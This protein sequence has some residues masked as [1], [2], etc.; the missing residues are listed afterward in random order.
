[1]NFADASFYALGEIELK[2]AYFLLGQKCCRFKTPPTRSAIWFMLNLTSSDQTPPA[3][4][5][6]SERGVPGVSSSSSPEIQN[7]E[8]LSKIVLVLLLE[9]G[10][11]VYITKPAF[12]SL[13]SWPSIFNKTANGYAQCLSR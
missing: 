6:F 12:D 2:H 8:V 4:M 10:T 1:M 5:V 9:R 11:F 7:Y 13:P 3:S